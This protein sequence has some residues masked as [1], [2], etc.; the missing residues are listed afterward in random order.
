M[1]ADLPQGEP[2]NRVYSQDKVIKLIQKDREA[3]IQH[4]KKSFS[5][6][7]RDF[8]DEVPILL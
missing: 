6:D 7:M 3:V 4:I 5:Y 1:S 8:F 2:A